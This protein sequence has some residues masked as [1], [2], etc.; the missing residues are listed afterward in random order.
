MNRSRERHARCEIECQDILEPMGLNVNGQ[1]ADVF[2]KYQLV[3]IFFSSTEEFMF[4]SQRLLKK[5]TFHHFKIN[6]RF[7]HDPTWL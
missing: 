3:F 6:V 1:V 7:V 4:S 5:R 2:D